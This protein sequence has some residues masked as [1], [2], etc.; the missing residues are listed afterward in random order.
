MK[1]TKKKLMPFTKEWTEM[2]R[3]RTKQYQD[4]TKER[5]ERWRTAAE[6]ELVRQITRDEAKRRAELEEEARKRLE[7]GTK[8]S[9]QRLNAVIDEYIRFVKP[10]VDAADKKKKEA[11]KENNYVYVIGERVRLKNKSI[12]KIGRSSHPKKRLY[13]IVSNGGSETL[14]VLYTQRCGEYAELLEY[15]VHRAL[16]RY[17]VGRKGERFRVTKNEAV[18]TIVEEFNK[19]KK[20]RPP[21]RPRREGIK[22]SGKHLEF[23]ATYRETRSIGEACKHY[24][25]TQQSIYR[26]CSDNPA[27]KMLFEIVRHIVS[28]EKLAKI[29]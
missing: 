11:D 21:V 9:G 14:Q 4:D 8:W 25:L 12:I 2:V 27:F 16:A 29:K 6:K 24:G 22:R 3:N 10:S 23:L 18:A 13:N 19:I 7:Y 17:R 26:E 20:E 5:E 28:R 1:K 15:R